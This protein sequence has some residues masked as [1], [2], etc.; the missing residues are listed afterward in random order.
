MAPNTPYVFELSSDS[1]KQV[2]TVVAIGDRKLKYEI[3]LDSEDSTLMSGR[4]IERVSGIATWVG[5]FGGVTD[6]GIL[7]PDSWG[8]RSADGI[9][10]FTLFGEYVTHVQVSVLPIHTDAIPR[11][12]YRDE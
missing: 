2:I 3:V 12:G 9:M 11:V 10:T 6:D 1:S 4:I 7:H 5:C 8:Y